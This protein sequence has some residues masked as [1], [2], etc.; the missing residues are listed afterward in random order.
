V[1]RYFAQRVASDND[2]TAGT[3][4]H[5]DLAVYTMTVA[6]TDAANLPMSVSFTTEL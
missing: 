6:S 5:D 4:N 3:C 2:D 1:I